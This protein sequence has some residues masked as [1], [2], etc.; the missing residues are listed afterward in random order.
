M[1]RIVLRTLRRIAGRVELWNG[2]RE[3]WENFF[4]WDPEESV[5]SWAWHQH[6][7]Y[8]ARYMAAAAEPGHLTFVRLRS[9]RAARRFVARARL[10]AL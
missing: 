10:N 1:R 3:R 8:R 9:P 2:N 5:I 6:A 7:T 4:T